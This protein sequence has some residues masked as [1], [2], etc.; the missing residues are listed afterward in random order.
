M[1]NAVKIG[2][3]ILSVCLAIL[4]TACPTGIRKARALERGNR[5]FAAGEY[6]KAKIEYLIVLRGDPQN[7]RAIQ[8]LGFIWLEQG[9]PFRAAPF[10]L[11]TRDLAP[12]NTQARTK[13]ALALMGLGQ[14][15]EARKEGLAVLQQDPA[16]CDA[17]LV[18]ADAS[19]SKDVVADTEQQLKK[20]SQQNSACF[21]LAVASVALRKG[22][23]E[24]AGSE[25]QKAVTADPKSRQAH[26][27]AAYLCLLR[28]DVSHAGQEFK[29]AADLAPLRSSERIKYAEFQAANGALA[30]AKAY[31]EGLTKQVPDYIPAWRARAQIALAEK[32][33]G[34]SLSLL[35]NIFSRDPQN[36]DVRLFQSEVLLAKGDPDEAITILD[37]LDATFRNNPAVKY[38]LG[39][40]Y[41]QKKNRTQAMTALELAV[42]AN[43]NYTDAVLLLDE[44]RLGA[45]KP[46][47]VAND[48]ELLLKK[49]PDLWPARSLLARS[50]QALGRLDDAVAVLR[51]QIKLTPQSA[52]AYLLTGII[53]RQ[54][55]KND[56]ARR[57]F[58]KAA[59][60]APDSP[61]APD[62]LVEMDIADN[63][64][65]LAMDRVQQQF[66]NK[67]D[68]PVAHFMEAKVYA[69]QEDW[70]HTEAALHKAIELD[71]NFAPA[72]NLLISAYLEQDKLPQAVS[73]IEAGLAKEPT[74]QEAL[75][76][77]GQV[78]D[79]LKDYAKARNAYE[80]LLAVNPNST[81]ALNNLA[82]LYC[83]RFNQLDKA[84]QLAQQAHNLEPGDASIADTLGWILYKRGDYQG[85]LALLRESA[86]KIPD[87]PE[88]QFHLGMT[89]YM[90][91]QSDAAK[92]AF[93]QA[94][95]APDDFE[96]K[97]EVQRRLTLLQ[98][99]T[100][101]S[102]ELTVA[103][104]ETLQKQQPEDL[105]VVKS[106]AEAYEKHGDFAK[107]AI[108]YGQALKLNPKLMGAALKLAQLYAERL[109]NR[110]KALEFAKKARE[111][112]PTDAEV[113]GVL[114]HVASESG[115]YSWAFS[116]LQESSRQRRT[117][118]AVLYDLGSAAYAL[119]KVPE[120]RQA[121]ERSLTAA[122]QSE[123]AKRF[124][125]MIAL[126]RLSPEV[127][128]AEPEVQK[129]LKAQ[130]NYVP[131]LMAQGAIQLQ[132]NDPKTATQI[133][134]R[135][136]SEY[137]DFAPAQK[138]LAAIYVNNPQ[139][140]PRAYELAVKARKTLPDDPEV[141]RTLAEVSFKRQDFSYAIQ[142]LEGS[143]AK[144]GLTAKDLYYLGVAQLQTKQEAKGRETLARALAAGL[145]DPLAQDAKQRL[146]PQRGK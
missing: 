55:Q 41:L 5:Y 124:L 45:S 116:L 50:Y 32:N 3:K 140:M 1:F 71:S 51:D 35:E 74:N 99:P 52:D 9:V 83:E 34:E 125:A 136:L 80:K 129:I 69:A 134:Q 130:P 100:G 117:D 127:V 138:R 122:P 27:A 118:P 64:Y 92:A 96:D 21:H 121:V 85:A 104:L 67:A 97:A 66:H 113:A 105:I 15:A 53:L 59:E 146:P 30:D 2:A 49:R 44:L 115:N 94:V 60:L 56:E 57:A 84:Y 58:E 40:A 109:H 70:P 38:Y 22:D 142:L 120:A 43:S 141:A 101:S 98:G 93:E 68:T 7:A 90:M 89:N 29:T 91:G 95:Q 14:T 16:N 112:A 36:P 128:A 87:D 131:A 62:Q 24:M 42:A 8:Q 106:L 10:L 132:R 39:R 54:Q 31:L 17:I 79:E 111:L 18:L 47:P 46:Q 77:L 20:F 114:G 75:A 72:Y 73:Q 119:G 37:R 145:Q 26:L 63:R 103:Q 126:D 139:D 25:T 133:Y 61:A 110:D 19:Q 13:L 123:E 12:Q 102:S 11:R 33:Y 28:R 76:T 107:A 78:Y 6:D 82:D 143:A 144:E 137:P 108:A 65:D 48:M 23:I 81:T 86:E 135:I 88:V 4:L